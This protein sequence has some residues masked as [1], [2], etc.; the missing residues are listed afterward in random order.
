MRI[1][2]TAILAV[3]VLPREERLLKLWTRRSGLPFHGPTQREVLSWIDV[4]HEGPV[5]PELGL[6]E[7]RS[8]RAQF[9]ASC[10]WTSFEEVL[11]LF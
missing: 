3:F 11:T 2:S 4:L 6:D 1:K 5:P 8:V 10:G 7:L 9:I